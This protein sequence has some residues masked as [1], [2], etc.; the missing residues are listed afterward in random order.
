[1]PRPP[2]YFIPDI[3]QHVIQRGVDQQAVFFESGDYELYLRTLD[4]AANQYD[5]QI[6]AYVLMTNHTH[7]LVTPGS[8]RSIP[9]VMQ[10]IGR[11]YVQMLNKKY[12]R[13]GTLWEG[14][15][16][17]SLVQSD[18]YLMACHKYIELNPVRAGLVS[19]PGEYPYSSFAHNA[20]GICDA[21]LTPHAVYE[22]LAQTSD[23]RRVAYRSL[24]HDSIAPDLLATIRDTTNACLV[25][26]TDCFRDQIEAM[27]GRSVRHRKNGRPRKADRKRP[28]SSKT[29]V[30]P[31][32]K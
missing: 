15:Y 28:S 29:S 19:T 9:L 22:S 14:R 12:D 25:L 32:L 7:L 31:H 24:F 3:P 10:A 17:A 30:R 11:S 18:A 27:L 26:G 23:E 1:M 6:H 13:T 5:C 2:R 16:K 20:R 21:L 8:A 4:K